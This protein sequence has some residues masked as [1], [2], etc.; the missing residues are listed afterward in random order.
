[1]RAP[2]GTINLDETGR[3]AGRGAYVCR[4]EPCLQRAIRTGALGRAL[5]T[6]LPADVL[7][8][9]AETITTEPPTDMTTRHTDEGGARG[10]E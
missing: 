2:D 1:V 5:E 8:A 7:S 6:K 4:Q 10:Q 3:A 9:L